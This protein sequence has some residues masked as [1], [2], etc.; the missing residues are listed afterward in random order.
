MEKV[1]LLTVA[2]RKGFSLPA[3]FLRLN[4]CGD[5]KH[6][7]IVHHAINSSL[8]KNMHT[9]RELLTQGLHSDRS[10]IP[11]LFSRRGNVRAL[12]PTRGG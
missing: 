5:K 3:D 10:T 6:K 8:Y 9:S 4:K 1:P 12:A 2:V 11:R 7:A